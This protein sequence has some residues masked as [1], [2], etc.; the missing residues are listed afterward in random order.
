M[1]GAF[2][3]IAHANMAEGFRLGF[4]A[5]AALQAIATVVAWRMEDLRLRSGAEAVKA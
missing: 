3:A 2:L 1:A 5:C 4:L